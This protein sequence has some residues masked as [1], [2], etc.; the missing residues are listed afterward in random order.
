M[1]QTN[2]GGIPPCAKFQLICDPTEDKHDKKKNHWMDVN[3][4]EM[5]VG[6]TEVVVEEEE[7]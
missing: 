5:A 3:V 1:L 6:G 4:A 2:P 7:E